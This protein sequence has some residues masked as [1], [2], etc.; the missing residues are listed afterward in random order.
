MAEGVGGATAVGSQL[1]GRS[2]A[3]PLDAHD[4]DTAQQRVLELNNQD[5]GDKSGAQ[6]RT[7]GRTPDGTGMLHL[8]ILGEQSLSHCS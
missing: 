3:K 2:S 5:D 8:E 7:Y 6:K 4:P 1:R